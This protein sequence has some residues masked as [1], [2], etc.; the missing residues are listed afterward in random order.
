[1][2]YVEGR[3]NSRVYILSALVLA[4]LSLSL[5]FAAFSAVLNISSSAGVRI[6]GPAFGV[7]FSSSG[8]SYQTNPVVPTKSSDDVTTTNATIDNTTT[9]TLNNVTATFNRPGQTVTYNLYV[10]NQGN[11]K[12]Y[13]NSITFKG[14]KTCSAVN[15]DNTK[16][17]D[18][19]CDAIKMSVKIGDTT[20]MQTLGNINEPLAKKQFKPLTIT[21]TYDSEGTY[22]DEAFNVAFPSIYL[23]CE[24]TPEITK[25]VVT[26]TSLSVNANNLSEVNLRDTPDQAMADWQDI[27]GTPGETRPFY[28]KLILSTG[29][30]RNK[31]KEYYVEFVVTQEMANADSGMTAGTYALIGGNYNFD[32][33]ALIR[34]FGSSNC[35]DQDACFIC[36]GGSGDGLS[37]RSCTG[38]YASAGGYATYEYCA[39]N[40]SGNS[41]CY[42]S[43]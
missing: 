20:V 14:D 21:L 25:Y 3:K 34:A 23:D 42:Y 26:T 19:A 28:L 1:M 38:G 13:I 2:I 40:S 32:R 36:N 22:S 39:L 30:T 10:Y 6:S 31:I 11:L 4:V 29:T 27:I 18:A 43:K 33:E 35:H 17:V 7:V 37:A 9:P 16:Y 5:G 12:A 15:G 24:T 8:E 41:Y